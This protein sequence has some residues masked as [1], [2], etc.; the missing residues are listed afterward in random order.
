M[1]G[2]EDWNCP[3]D[4]SSEIVFSPYVTLSGT[5]SPR[6]LSTG[7][8]SWRG[9]G[10]RKWI[11]RLSTTILNPLTADRGAAEWISSLPACRASHFLTQ[12]RA[13]ARKMNDGS[14]KTLSGSVLRLGQNSSFLRTSQDFFDTDLTALP[15]DWPRSGTMRNGEIF[16]RTKPAVRRTRGNAFSSSPSE[17]D[18]A[19]K[20]YPTPAATPYGTSQNEGKVPHKRPSAGTPSL[21]TW[22]KTKWA[23]PQAHDGRRPGIDHLS[24]QEFN[25]SRQAA[26]WPT[27]T[28]ALGDG[29]Q[30]SRSGGR[31]GEQLL[32]GMA[33]HWPTPTSRDWK[34]GAC[35]N[36]DVESNALLGRV[37]VRWP[38]PTAGDAKM[39]GSR[40][41]PGSRAH[42][43]ASLTDMVTTGD[44]VGRSSRPDPTTQKA[45]QTGLPWVDPNLSSWPTPNAVQGNAVGR[46]DEMG[47]SNNP[48]RGTNHGTKKLNPNFV[49]ALMGLPQNFSNPMP[50]TDSDVAEMRSYLYRAASLLSHLLDG[51]G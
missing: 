7:T 24:A 13:R 41:V 48:F 34:D 8:K 19:E 18:Q 49:E 33:K 28:K 2:S 47:G 29:G 50:V 37:A 32:T 51:E 16:A 44:A 22:A 21:E 25:L 1:P 43:G 12:A 17:T 6:P 11:S 4:S 20:H 36:Q 46:L 23:T 35:E 45:G 42:G 27:P 38:T 40:E 9:W 14:E 10:A 3:S 39:S 15:E 26:Q 31:K 5:A 30:T